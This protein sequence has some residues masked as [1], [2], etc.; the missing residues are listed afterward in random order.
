LPTPTN[1]WSSFIGYNCTV[2][3]AYTLKVTTFPWSGT[4][5]NPFNI[6]VS[7]MGAAVPPPPPPPGPPAGGGIPN[8]KLDLPMLDLPKQNGD[9]LVSVVYSSLMGSTLAHARIEELP[10]QLRLIATR[11]QVIG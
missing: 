7:F 9:A 8:V 1:A 6:K 3:G 5:P 2:S 10:Q 11:N 4:T